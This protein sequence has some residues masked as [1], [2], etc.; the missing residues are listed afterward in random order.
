MWCSSNMPNFFEVNDAPYEINPELLS[1]NGPPQLD[2]AVDGCD[3]RCN[4]GGVVGEGNEDSNEE[5]DTSTLVNSEEDS[6]PSTNGPEAHVSVNFFGA[7]ATDDTRRENE[8]RTRLEIFEMGEDGGGFGMGELYVGQ[9][10]A[11]FVDDGMADSMR[12]EPD[13]NE[14]QSVVAPD[15]RSVRNISPGPGIGIWAAE[16]LELNGHQFNEYHFLVRPL[17]LTPQRRYCHGP[18][19]SNMV[20]GRCA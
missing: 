12:N 9:R 4:S 7:L 3:C 17:R 11:Q 10:R 19:T 1:C 16:E 20:C 5:D 13:G 6:P 15:A 2:Q 18:V 8:V 14:N